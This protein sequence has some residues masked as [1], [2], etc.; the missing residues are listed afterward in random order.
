M[1]DLKKRQ[2]PKAVLIRYQGNGQVMVRALG[3]GHLGSRVPGKVPGNV[4]VPHVTGE[5]RAGMI[6]RS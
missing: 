2:G 4:Q 1:E 6:A 5:G 3:V